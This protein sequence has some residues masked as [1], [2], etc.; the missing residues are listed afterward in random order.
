MIER[1]ETERKRV[2]PPL[3]RKRLAS[4]RGATEQP[5]VTG[6]GDTALTPVFWAMVA[7]TG[8]AS[9]LF[10]D[11]LMYVLFAVQHLAFNYHS[12]SLQAAVEHASALRRVASLLVAGAFGGVAWY[13]LRRWPGRT[14]PTTPPIP[15]SPPTT[16]R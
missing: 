15:I 8:V 2:P 6:D 5:N 14:C 16:S 10:G 4:G 3:V 13:L 1:A 9:G 12:G 7:L 11:A